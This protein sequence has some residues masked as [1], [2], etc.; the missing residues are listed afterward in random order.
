MKDFMDEFLRLRLGFFRRRRFLFVL[1]M[2]SIFS[3]V[4]AIF[5]ILNLEYFIEKWLFRYELFVLAFIIAIAFTFLLHKKDKKI[6]LAILIENKCPELR[7]KLRT[8]YDNRK[9]SN[10]ILDSLKNQVSMHLTKISSSDL[11]STAKMILRIIVTIIFISGSVMITLNPE[12]Y[13]IPPEV[14]TGMANSITSKTNKT[15]EDLGF[16]RPEIDE[17]TGIRG[18]GE[19]F[20]KPKIASIQSKNIDLTIYSG[21]GTG[22]E[23]RETSQTQAEFISSAEFPVD[24][25]G[26][27]VSDSEYSILMKKTQSEKKLINK[28]A[29]ERSKIREG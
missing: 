3:I 12:E 2:V 27:N 5:I 29:I 28:Y 10:V 24:V 13:A 23:L 17:K 16:G 6:N 7:E 8:A 26:S 9:E 20:G 25:L 11:L 14:L 1:D 22:F 18:K 4:Y 21:I 19:I 15:I